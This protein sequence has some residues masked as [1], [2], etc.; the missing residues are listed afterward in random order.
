MLGVRSA[1]KQIW[2]VI[3]SLG[4]IAV[5]SSVRDPALKNRLEGLVRWLS[6]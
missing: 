3:V 6:R 4:K 5:L 1:S 2:A